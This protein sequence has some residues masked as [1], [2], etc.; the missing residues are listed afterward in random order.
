MLTREATVAKAEAARGGGPLTRERDPPVEAM[1]EAAMGERDFFD[2]PSDAFARGGSA[3]KAAVPVQSAAATTTTTA[4]SRT[5]V[6]PATP[7]RRRSRRTTPCP[8]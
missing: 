3:G 8:T 4:T 6:D 7:T 2:H 1:A 5:M